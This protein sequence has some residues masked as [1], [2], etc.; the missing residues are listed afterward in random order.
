M[1]E[2]YNNIKILV[3]GDSCK[4][5]FVYGVVPRLAPE[6]P[7]PVF[8]PLHS[9]EN[10]GMASNVYENLRA[11]G[12]NPFLIT[13][14]ET[15]VKTRYVD[16]RTNSLLLRV[17]TN[18]K[19]TRINNDLLNGIKNNRFQGVDYDAI[20]ISDY[21]KGFLTE[22]DIDNIARYNYNI[23]LD[24][25]KILGD[26]CK[27]VSYIKINQA[28][29]EKTKHTIAKLGIVDQLIITKSNDGCQH[30]NKIYPVEDVNVKDVSGAG[31]T[32][33]SGL[34]TEM[35]RT[36]NIDLAINFAQECATKVVQKLGVCTI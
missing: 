23:F 26:W 36:K 4:D 21:C 14:S 34:V 25:K 27:Y 24:T 35:V 7:I 28:E 31:D 20:V 11:I 3:I 17:D 9:K 19:A 29:Y 8:N 33:M 15:I 1:K 12:A 5:I 32:F 22:E 6:G 16:E 13:Q 2:N 30:K 18:D 10:N